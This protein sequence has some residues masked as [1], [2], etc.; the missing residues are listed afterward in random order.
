[1]GM[2]GPSHQEGWCPAVLS[3]WAAFG[4]SPPPTASRGPHC[5]AFVLQGWSH[6]AL[7][8]RLQRPVGADSRQVPLGAE[9]HRDGVSGPWSGGQ[10]EVPEASRWGPSGVCWHPS[11]AED[12]CTLCAHTAARTSPGLDGCSPGLNA[13]PCTPGSSEVPMRAALPRLCALRPPEGEGERRDGG[14][15]G[16]GWRPRRR[17]GPGG[18]RGGARSGGGAGRRAAFGS[19]GQPAARQPPSRALRGRPGS[20]QGHGSGPGPCASARGSRKNSRG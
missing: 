8:G 5:L 2:S 17:T 4:Q 16:D 9:L 20:R 11:H 1:M 10:V 6:S 15:A 19:S 18:A 14:G 12:R 7:E 13:R 3:R